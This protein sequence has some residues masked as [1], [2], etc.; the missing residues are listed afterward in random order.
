MQLQGNYAGSCPISDLAPVR[1]VGA[2]RGLL[3]FLIF[4]LCDTDT[5]KIPSFTARSRDTRG[6]DLYA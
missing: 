4:L 2:R 6:G 3:P 1:S 5:L